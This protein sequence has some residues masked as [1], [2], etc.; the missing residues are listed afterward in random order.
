MTTNEVDLSPL[1]VTM[2]VQLGP[3]AR[4]CCFA[5]APQ[6]LH[7]SR[8]RILDEQARWRELL[9]RPECG[10]RLARATERLEQDA[11]QSERR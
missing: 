8:Q 7:L 2:H 3:P 5:S 9:S 6:R 1:R 4:G 10:R 11:P